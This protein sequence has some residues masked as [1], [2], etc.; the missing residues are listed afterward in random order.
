MIT[1]HRILAVILRYIY[2]IWR[3]VGQVFDFMYWPLMDIL[4]FG[5]VS[6][7]MNERSGNA[8]P[9]VT[10][11][12]LTC[13]VL[14]QVMYRGNLEIALA[15]LEDI[16]SRNLINFFSSPIL[17]AEWIIGVMLLGMI[18][19]TF[20]IMYGALIC[21]LVYGVNVFS[22]GPIFILYALLAMMSGWIIGFTGSLMIISW[23]EKAAS[24]AWAMGWFFAPFSAV[25]YPLD[26]LPQI[27]Q[28]IAY[29]LPMTYLFESLRELI[30]TGVVNTTSLI[31]IALLSLIYVTCALFSFWRMFERSRCNGLERLY[32]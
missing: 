18:K 13:L 11:K 21:W 25:F 5:Y 26:V 31:T 19:T 17:I 29:C 27:M 12:M 32:S 15:I 4:L 8:E 7:W 23:G 1:I 22:I 16:W 24:V 30:G 6:V 20:T 3:N 2:S 14:W 9:L 10:A 28:S